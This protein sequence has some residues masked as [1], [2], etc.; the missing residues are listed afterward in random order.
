MILGA[1][2]LLL[3]FVALL[4]ACRFLWGFLRDAL[5]PVKENYPNPKEFEFVGAKIITPFTME[6]LLI[7]RDADLNEYQFRGSSS[8][9]HHYPGGQRAGHLWGMWSIDVE[10]CLEALW[11][12][13]VKWKEGCQDHDIIDGDTVVAGSGNKISNY[14]R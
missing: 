3:W 5:S 1:F 10:D 11:L 12:A 6:C 8:V 7:V 9:W 13:N 14:M 2:L 4:F